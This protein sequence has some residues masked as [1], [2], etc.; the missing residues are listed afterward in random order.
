MQIRI[1]FFSRLQLA[2]MIV[3][4]VG[5]APDGL[6]GQRSEPPAVR[7]QALS[8]AGSAQ[9]KAPQGSP[10]HVRRKA[11]RLQLALL[12]AKHPGLAPVNWPGQD[13]GAL[14]NLLQAMAAEHRQLRG[15]FAPQKGGM[16]VTSATPTTEAEQTYLAAKAK[17]ADPCTPQARAYLAAL[18]QQLF[19]GK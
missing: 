5:C 19:Q 8:P 17:L 15:S 1:C 6:E 12:K 18:K 16:A 3:A 11:L 7:H 9:M 14:D 2:A 10:S 4:G 13:K